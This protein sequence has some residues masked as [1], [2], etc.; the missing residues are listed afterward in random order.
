[1]KGCLQEFWILSVVMLTSYRAGGEAGKPGGQEERSYEGSS[2]A[3]RNKAGLKFKKA[4]L[5]LAWSTVDLSQ[6]LKEL[7]RMGGAWIW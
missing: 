4:K 5:L 7:L 6:C 3:N 1:M 2:A